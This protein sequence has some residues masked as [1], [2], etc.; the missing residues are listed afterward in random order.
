MED[1]RCWDATLPHHFPS[2]R[3]GEG[4]RTTSKERKQTIAPTPIP[5]SQPPLASVSSL[6]VAA[7]F[8]SST[9]SSV[10]D[11][12][13]SLS[14][15]VSVEDATCLSP[16]AATRE[17][18]GKDHPTG[19]FP[20]SATSRPGP[21]TP[22]MLTRLVPL[23]GEEITNGPRQDIRHGRGVASG[24][25]REVAQRRLSPAV[26]EKQSY[27]H[28]GEDDGW[29]PRGGR[30][31]VGP[32]P[33][34]M[35][36]P[37]PF[38]PIL[39]AMT[40]S[41]LP[42]AVG[43]L[44]CTTPSSEKGGAAPLA[45]PT[46]SSKQGKR[47]H[48]RR[49]SG[50][51]SMPGGEDALTAM[52]HLP[53]HRTAASPPSPTGS[54]LR[55]GEGGSQEKGWPAFS[56]ATPIPKKDGDEGG[57]AMGSV[58]AAH[59][60]STPPDERQASSPPTGGV[61]AFPS[62]P[63]ALSAS[64]PLPMPM[65]SATSASAILAS[66]PPADH[67]PSGTA[68]AR[69]GSE[70]L[71]AK[72]PPQGARSRHGSAVLTASAHRGKKNTLPHVEPFTAQLRVVE[73]ALLLFRASSSS[74]SPLQKVQGGRHGDLPETSPKRRP[75]SAHR[76][77]CD[78]GE[79][80]STPLQS[81]WHRPRRRSDRP[82][83]APPIPSSPPP[84]TDDDHPRPRD[85]LPS[86]PFSFSLH[87]PITAPSVPPGT[88]A[89]GGPA[90]GEGSPAASW[91]SSPSCL[92]PDPRGEEWCHET[93]KE[94]LHGGVWRRGNGGG[95]SIMHPHFTYVN[96][97]K[98][99]TPRRGHSRA[100]PTSFLTGVG[101]LEWCIHGSLQCFWEEGYVEGWQSRP[102]LSAL[103]SFDWEE[104]AEESS[105]V[106]EK[107]EDA[108][109]SSALP[110]PVGTSSLDMA[111]EE[112]AVGEEH[113]SPLH[114]VT[115][116]ASRTSAS[117]GTYVVSLFEWTHRFLPEQRR[118]LQE[119]LIAQKEQ[120]SP[121]RRPASRLAAELL[122]AM[123]SAS[124]NG[125]RGSVEYESDVDRSRD[126]RHRSAAS[127][128]S[129]HSPSP[130]VEADEA[131]VQPASRVRQESSTADTSPSS[132]CASGSTVDRLPWSVELPTCAGLLFPIVIPPGV[133]DKEYPAFF[134][135][136]QERSAKAAK[137]PIE[138]KSSRVDDEGN[139]EAGEEEEEEEAAKGRP[140]APLAP[141][142]GLPYTGGL[143]GG[144]RGEGVLY[145]AKMMWP[146]VAPQAGRPNGR[147]T[148]EA[149]KAQR[150][151]EG[152]DGSGVQGS[153]SPG[154]PTPSPFE[155]N[156]ATLLYAP[157]HITLYLSLLR[158]TSL[159]KLEEL[160][161]E[162][163]NRFSLQS[164]I[165]S[166][167]TGK[168]VVVSFFYRYRYVGCPL[169]WMKMDVL[170][171]PKE[172]VEAENMEKNEGGER[173]EAKANEGNLPDNVDTK[174]GKTKRRRRRRASSSVGSTSSSSFSFLSSTPSESSTCSSSAVEENDVFMLFQAGMGRVEVDIPPQVQYSSLR[175]L[176][177]LLHLPPSF[178][179]PLLWNVVVYA[180]MMVVS[181]WKDYG[182]N[183]FT[184]YKHTFTD[185]VLKITSEERK[186]T[187]AEDRLKLVG[188]AV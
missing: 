161:G 51:G 33:A 12:A 179:L 172:E 101:P 85:R 46:L 117:S 62:S 82:P 64:A 123:P 83:H 81:Q 32:S 91:L 140:E 45:Q 10:E 21:M 116:K 170:A 86:H 94:E 164:V 181:I 38:V 57:G 76:R 110:S 31:A 48:S 182:G 180:S 18:V 93:E 59:P 135:F 106:V 154:A 146:P 107:G 103:P 175:L 17:A 188:K 34:A 35:V 109:P 7:A 183:F 100:T 177:R 137:D 184:A 171:T 27:Q 67:N 167:V 74:S 40:P 61:P 144:R 75:S 156:V 162:T 55:E 115:R 155:T 41:S 87:S 73:E 160:R 187:E 24:G 53:P 52:S 121:P 168:P 9:S 11:L 102:R 89:S 152:I 97:Q 88:T 22:R 43:R 113:R 124:I 105:E 153:L 151:G 14:S 80:T 186:K 49:G 1:A 20:P 132:P 138:H 99:R 13:P 25:P 47:R 142:S 28:G 69:S 2:S 122:G 120:Q 92:S 72:P 169:M 139:T 60:L 6:L 178:P 79:G 66:T 42:Q 8:P 65:P 54:S 133:G 136:L 128:L 148:E 174:K 131:D 56:A 125:S 36:S 16:P 84:K 111:A 26:A 157:S 173:T 163:E 126:T 23:E 149:P 130:H 185:E 4:A 58:P 147:T 114:A 44:S 50:N 19:L 63:T 141:L 30:E 134:S 165:L 104:K 77:G 127:S 119:F 112:A 166:P 108:T 78:G 176:L 39:S 150:E 68:S 98:E 15:A 3:E 118:E 129:S 70:A 5:P 37:T 96:H 90:T 158:Y 29:K 95:W 145:K 159:Y 71:P 143:G